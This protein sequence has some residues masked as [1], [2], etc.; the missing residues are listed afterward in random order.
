MSSVLLVHLFE[1]Y[2]RNSQGGGEAYQALHFIQQ[3]T[4]LKEKI[5]QGFYYFSLLLLLFTALFITMQ[6]PTAQDSIQGKDCSLQQHPNLVIPPSF[7]PLLQEAVAEIL[8]ILKPKAR[9]DWMM[10]C[11]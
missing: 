2:N 5:L 6:T 3:V 7:K 4:V 8:L 9:L 1:Q 11:F 10:I